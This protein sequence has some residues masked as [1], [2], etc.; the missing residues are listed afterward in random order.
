MMRHWK[1]ERF[2]K[3]MADLGGFEIMKEVRES[4]EELKLWSVFDGK[5]LKRRE[6]CSKIS[7][8]VDS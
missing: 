6:K 1:L 2:S 8:F 5:I 4:R 7:R 3:A